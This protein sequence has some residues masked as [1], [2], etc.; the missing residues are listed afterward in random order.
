MTRLTVLCYQ[1]PVFKLN[2][3][4]AFYGKQFIAC[5]KNVC[6]TEKKIEYFNSD[7][8]DTCSI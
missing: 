6:K 1:E 8:P 4:K 3:V 2:K 7:M 5:E